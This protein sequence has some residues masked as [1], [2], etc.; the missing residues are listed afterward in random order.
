MTKDKMREEILLAEPNNEIAKASSSTHAELTKELSA[1]KRRKASRA[2]SEAVPAVVQYR[3]EG[4]ENM[5]YKLVDG[6]GRELTGL[7]YADELPS[8]GLVMD[9]DR[10]KAK[11]TKHDNG[12]KIAAADLAAREAFDARRIYTTP[13][14][15]SV[16][17]KRQDGGRVVLWSY[18]VQA[19][20]MIGGQVALTRTDRTAQPTASRQRRLTQK[21]LASWL[22]SQNPDITAN[23]LFTELK[24]TFPSAA[25]G[26]RH[27]P[28]YLS[29]S[30]NGHLPE[31]PD[32]D[33]RL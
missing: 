33:P 22:I 18:R 25:I 1:V 17:Y 9:T 19:E 12:L 5:S 7:I 26:P 10:G 20:I 30:R 23:E 28:H 29:L 21:L 31:P 14:G 8:I 11:V 2:S 13:N 15:T 16:V 4:E 6:S 32:S 27:G 24:E 3:L